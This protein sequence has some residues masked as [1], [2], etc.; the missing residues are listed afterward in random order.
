M[1]GREQC[2]ARLRLDWVVDN[3]RAPTL[4]DLAVF[5]AVF[6][7]KGFRAA[8]LRLGV[9]P[10]HVSNTITRVEAHLGVPLFVRSTRSVRPTEAGRE[11]AARFS[12]LLEQTRVVLDDVGSM[13]RHVRGELKL[14]VTSAVMTDILPPILARFAS[15]HPGVHVEVVVE[16]RLVDFIAEG[17]TA[18]VRYG[19]NMAQD[20]IAVP[21]G[22]RRQ[23]SALAAAPSYLAS[24]GLP[25][26]PGELPGHRC[27]RLRLSSGRLK[28]WH[29]ERGSEALTVD[30][31]AHLVVSI[32]AAPAAIDLARAGLGLICTVRSW[33][34]PL[35]ASGELVPVLQDWW[36]SF[37]GPKLYFSSRSMPAPL[38]AFVDML[39]E[40]LPGEEASG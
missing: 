27:I 3:S 26:H 1:H 23:Q 32:A 20:M 30:P 7:G 14:N 31:P 17:C 18:G 33:L 34:D 11:L 15:R 36:P 13:G 24:R 4:N 37:E 5:M 29:F 21:L 28:G 25:T 8:A 9:S 39:A 35:L 16:D 6:E 38:R 40:A 10:S 19:R 22:P 12:P 2:A